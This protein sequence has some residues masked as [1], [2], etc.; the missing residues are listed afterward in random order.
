[1]EPTRWLPYWIQ[2]ETKVTVSVFNILQATSIE[3]LVE[4]IAELVGGKSE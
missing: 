4:R 2:R 1:M 3:S